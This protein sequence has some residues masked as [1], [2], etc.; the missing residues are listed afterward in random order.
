MCSISTKSRRRGEWWLPRIVERIPRT[1]VHRT[2][3]GG[4]HLVFRHRRACAVQPDAS[5]WRRCQGR[6]RLLHLVASVGLSRALRRSR[7]H[8]GRIGFSHRPDRPR[9]RR[10]VRSRWCQTTSSFA[11]SS[12]VIGR[13]TAGERN[14]ALYWAA[15]RFAE[16]TL[17]PDD[18]TALLLD[19]ASKIGLPLPEARGTIKS[20]FRAHARGH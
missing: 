14:H 1:R 11:A 2:R 6:R 19:A 5:R 9:R 20:A 12:D 16:T 10:Y 8:R 4:L 18:A 13:A 7:P 3:S 15:C 17:A